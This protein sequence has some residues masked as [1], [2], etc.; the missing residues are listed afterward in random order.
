MEQKYLKYKYKYLSLKKGGGLTNTSQNLTN[1]SSYDMSIAY[2]Q[3]TNHEKFRDVKH[4]PSYDTSIT[5]KQDTNHEKFRDVKHKP[6]YDTSIVNLTQKPSHDTSLVHLNIQPDTKLKY[7]DYI[8]NHVH[9]IDSL[10][11]ISFHE[12]KLLSELIGPISIIYVF[13]KISDETV[14]SNTIKNSLS[15]SDI[16]NNEFNRIRNFFINT[17]AIVETDILILLSEK[18]AKILSTFSINLLIH[19]Y[20]KSYNLTIRYN[21]NIVY[22]KHKSYCLLTS[23]DGELTTPVLNLNLTDASTVLIYKYQDPVVRMACEY[24]LLLNNFFV[25]RDNELNNTEIDKYY[26]FIRNDKINNTKNFETWF[27]EYLTE[28][29]EG[30]VCKFGYGYVNCCNDNLKNNLDKMYIKFNMFNLEKINIIINDEEY[31]NCS[32]ISNNE[33]CYKF[34]KKPDEYL[35]SEFIKLEK[36]FIEKFIIICQQ[37][38]NSIILKS[39]R[40]ED[41][42]SPDMTRESYPSISLIELLDK[43]NMIWIKRSERFHLTRSPCVHFGLYSEDITNKLC[44]FFNLEL[45]DYI[46]D[47]ILHS[48]GH[49]LDR[50]YCG[51]NFKSN[52]YSQSNNLIFSQIITLFDFFVN[53]M[54]KK[55]YSESD[56]SA[57]FL[58]MNNLNKTTLFYL[59]TNNTKEL[60]LYLSKNAI[61]TEREIIEYIIKSEHLGNPNFINI[62]SLVKFI[63]DL[64]LYNINYSYKYDNGERLLTHDCRA[65]KACAYGCQ[66]GDTQI[67]YRIDEDMPMFQ[68]I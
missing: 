31:K 1:P 5:Y 48:I 30:S 43:N 25:T 8:K 9:S 38:I 45:S 26:N 65:L 46:S 51:H 16:D 36:S 57:R 56:S 66:R 62:D 29:S 68:S 6:S 64:K 35:N 33:S 12:K 15:S 28:K 2:K 20:D 63:E 52:K 42:L 59:V 7:K 11:K 27:K 10:Y 53:L 18:D 21:K 55:D 4:K 40:A 3:D 37:T 44:N 41:N 54:K 60:F 50:L 17:E 49:S 19:Y 32:D 34:F 22:D 23:Y 13:D 14:N 47:I 24:L 58:N 39:G 61:T 67:E